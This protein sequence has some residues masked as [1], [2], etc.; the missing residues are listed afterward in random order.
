MADKTELVAVEFSPSDLRVLEE[1]QLQISGCRLASEKTGTG[2]SS[3]NAL[4]IFLKLSDE[5]LSAF[6]KE[7]RGRMTATRTT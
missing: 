4:S 2:R 1:L 6:V 7:L 3:V 5:K